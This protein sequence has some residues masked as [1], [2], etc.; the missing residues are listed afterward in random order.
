MMDVLFLNDILM[1]TT[2]ICS[3]SQNVCLNTYTYHTTFKMFDLN[4]KKLYG[5]VKPIEVKPIVK[6][7]HYRK[8]YITI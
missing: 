5:I 1:S 4:Y 2:N 6:P 3:R 8:N 7:Q